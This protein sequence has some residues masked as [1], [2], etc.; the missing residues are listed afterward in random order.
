MTGEDR[1]HFNIEPEELFQ[2][3]VEVQKYW[4]RGAK[5]ITKKIKRFRSNGILRFTQE[6]ASADIEKRREVKQL[7][8]QRRKLERERQLQTMLRWKPLKL[9]QDEQQIIAQ[10]ENILQKDAWSQ[11]RWLQKMK[12][13]KATHNRRWHQRSN[14]EQWKREKTEEQKQNKYN[15]N[16]DLKRSIE[17]KEKTKQSKLTTWLIKESND[18]G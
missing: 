6:A 15:Q 4:I 16:R 17:R 12:K 11:T 3:P 18:G 9:T 13:L 1:E 8:K 2:K 5:A 10:G 14:L 7:Q